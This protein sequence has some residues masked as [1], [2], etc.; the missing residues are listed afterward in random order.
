MIVLFPLP[1]GA[2]NIITFP[3]IVYNL[4]K[5]KKP[6]SPSPTLQEGGLVGGPATC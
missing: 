1:L 4:L 5:K 2:E 6:Y 3:G